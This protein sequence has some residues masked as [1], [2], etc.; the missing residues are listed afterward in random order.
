MYQVAIEQFL[1]ANKIPY[2]VEG[3]QIKCRC[4]NPKHVDSNPSFQFN[5]KEGYCHCFSC[6]WKNHITH[7][8]EV[9]MDEETMR[10]YEYQKL[11]EQLH[12]DNTET[13]GIQDIILP[14][15]A[16]PI[17]WMVRQISGELMRDLGVYYCER[18]KYMGRLIFPI[19][20]VD[21]V[22]LGYTSWIATAESLGEFADRLVEPQREHAKY[23]HSYGMTTADVLYPTMVM[24]LD[25]KHH[26]GLHLTEGLFDAL[27]LIQLGHPAVCNFGL[28]APSVHKV[29]E[30]LS[31]GYT[32]IIPAFDNDQAGM[33]GW[34]SIRDVWAEYVEIGQPTQILKDF[35]DYGANDANEYLTRRLDEN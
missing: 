17:T 13:L 25:V 31:M 1:T 9:E 8:T 32:K 28:G 29:G 2:K 18:G 23:L 10:Q 11:I 27:S 15:K 7:L 24:D 21:G 30:F 33:K 34:Q 35:R 3:D 14:P 22:L 19:T 16:F 12:V 26:E 6:G 20:D 4:L 5:T